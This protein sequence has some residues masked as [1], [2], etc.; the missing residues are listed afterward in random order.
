M[1]RTAKRLAQSALSTTVTNRVIASGAT[2]VQVTEIYLANTG[3][4]ERK[5]DLHHGGTADTNA[6]MRGITVPAGGCT[7]L[8]EMKIVVTSA[9]A[10]A[11]KQDTGTD[12]IMTAF[13]VE[14]V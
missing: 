9:Q 11:A 6:I 8:Q 5:V 1:A 14:E 3:T 4:T 10:L 7:I 12:V 2:V 13:G